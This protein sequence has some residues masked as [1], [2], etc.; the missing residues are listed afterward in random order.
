ML[1]RALSVAKILAELG[2]EASVLN[3]RWRNP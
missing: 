3:L 1:S 2:I